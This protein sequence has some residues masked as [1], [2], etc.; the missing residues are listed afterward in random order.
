MEEWSKGDYGVW[1]KKIQT[2]A[3]YIY[4]ITEVIIQTQKW[5]FIFL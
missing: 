4:N 3:F 2:Q 1:E 5:I